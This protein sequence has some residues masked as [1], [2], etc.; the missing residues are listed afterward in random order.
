MTDRREAQRILD[1]A[2]EQ[3]FHAQKTEAIGQLTG[4]VAHEFNNLL[5]V[6]LGNL[7]MARSFLQDSAPGNAFLHIDRAEQSSLRAAALTDR[8]LAFSRQQT[9]QPRPIDCNELVASMSGIIRPAVGENIA[10]E[11][12]LAGG[13]VADQR[14]SQ[15]T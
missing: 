3:L 2:Q 11:T 10:V 9:L 15:P 13:H 1:Q 6:I 7:E 12:V 8:L 14:G 4:G 5:T